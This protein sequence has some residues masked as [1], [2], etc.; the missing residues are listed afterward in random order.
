MHYY[1]R[2]EKI[3]KVSKPELRMGSFVRRKRIIL[4]GC[5]ALLAIAVSGCQAVKFY[6]QAVGGQFEIFQK[7][8]PIS[9]VIANPSTEAKLRQ[10]LQLVLDLRQFAETN[11]NL[12][13]DGQYLRY[14]DLGR[15]HVVWNVH[16]APEFSM[17]PKSWWYPFVGNAKYR[18]YF[19][20]QAAQSYGNKLRRQNLDVYVE[21]VDAYST[22]GW[23]KDPVLNTFIMDRDTG[24]AETI[25]HELAHQRVFTSGDT[26]FNEAFATSVGEEGVRRWIEGSK[27]ATNSAEMYEKYRASRHRKDQ[28]V[29]LIKET[30]QKL[31]ELYGETSD[32]IEP[33][34]APTGKAAED[35]RTRKES[36]IAG[37][38]AEYQKLKAEWGG[39]PGYDRWFNGPLNNAQLNTVSAYYD[40]VPAFAALL[41]EQNGDLEKFYTAV[42]EL[43][44]LP[45][46]E[47]HEKLRSYL[48][49]AAIA[50]KN[51]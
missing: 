10:K 31:K 27:G 36:V 21:G 3:G 44:K 1:L 46:K 7:Q 26:D 33:H 23:F 17:K 48:P 14:A 22:L 32:P 34:A 41:Q 47:R 19:S 35:L 13:S 49:K 16:A 37:L 30:R 8:K 43:A 51:N 2:K 20:E 9:K 5:I 4:I 12:K 40:L 24:L 42:D 6:S 15:E 11:L 29:H 50:A 18:G 39:Y 25:F 38:R 28:F 45:K